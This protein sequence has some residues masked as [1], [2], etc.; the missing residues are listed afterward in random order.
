MI[1]VL[2]AAAIAC[3][4]A[5]DALAATPT[6]L[7]EAATAPVPPTATAAALVLL[8]ELTVTVGSDGNLRTTRRYAVRINERSARHAASI[9]ESYLTGSGRIRSV[10]GWLIRGREA[11][12][13][14]GREYEADTALANNDVYNDVRVRSLSAADHVQAHDVF[15]AEL[16]SEDRIPFSQ[17][18]WPLQ[19]RWP[20]R[21]V[22][23]TLS[24]P[25]GWEARSV[26]FNAAP[27]QASSVGT[28]WIWEARDLEEISDD[29]AMPPMSAVIPRIAV[30]YFAPGGAVP[31]QF[32]D[33][34]GVS[35]WLHALSAATG[36][37]DTVTR[38][39]RELTANSAT[40][41]E[42]V[43][44]IAKYAQS[45]QYVSIQ[46]GTGRGGGYQPRAAAVVL[47][48]NYG[49]CKDKANLVRALLAA[50]GMKAY[51]VSLYSGDRDYV[52][53]EFPS[54]QQFNHAIVAIAMSDTRPEAPV[55]EHSTLGKLLIFDPTDEHTPFG[56][57][58]L[59]QQGSLALVVSANGGTL[60]RL[61]STPDKQHRI[62][63]TIEGVVDARGALK[64][65]MRERAYGNA[66]SIARAAFSAFEPTAYREWL[67]GRLSSIP[68]VR[69]LQGDHREVQ[70]AVDQTADFEAAAYGRSIGNL[71]I[72][73]PPMGFGDVNPGL[74]TKNRRTA[75]TVAPVWI[76]ETVTLELPGAFA[77]DEVP[78]AVAYDTPYGRYSLSYSRA[79]GR[80]IAH[81]V[82]ILHRQTV[83]PA[84]HPALKGFLEKIGAADSAPIVLSQSH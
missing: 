81:R 11:D 68:A 13:E 54:P 36:V 73:K 28:S 24:L 56:E 71:M 31:G 52:R 66:A 82:L 26:T 60:Q 65:R 3:V 21:V 57:L 51:L 40:E 76:D 4:T 83:P 39:A 33:W 7:R 27:I 80:L 14:L 50:I 2:I 59:E 20:V 67:Q 22:R 10:R 69:L 6:W 18:E 12:R 46:T 5:T 48:R 75:I 17:L 49:D 35:A 37:D 32:K 70:H 45:V 9:H 16:E 84:E 63:R 42:R 64:A 1:R 62:E 78:E 34:P 38:K 8:D 74:V 30:S 72:L 55:L 43:A 47:Q 25:A 29:P 44:A 61:P 58:P 53:A 19:D 79:E 23:R 77:I 41:F 15:G